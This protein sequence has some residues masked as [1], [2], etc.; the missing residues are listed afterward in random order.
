MIIAKTEYGDC[1]NDYAKMPA[2]MQN[3]ILV[4]GHNGDSERYDSSFSPVWYDSKDFEYS[5][6]H[7]YSG[8]SMAMPQFLYKGEIP[9][10]LMRVVAYKTT[11]YT[12]LTPCR[13][14]TYFC[15]CEDCGK[16]FV[17]DCYQTPFF[18]ARNLTLPTVRCS[19][20]IRKKKSN[21]KG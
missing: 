7:L 12:F 8:A 4:I 3:G 1:H 14:D 20:C 9:Y 17:I 11:L 19:E 15:K 18:K 10:E 6:D 13:D 21:N 16:N 5:C 2:Y